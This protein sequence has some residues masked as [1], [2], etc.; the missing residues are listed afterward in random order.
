MAAGGASLTA[1]GSW[2][3][4]IHAGDPNAV[5]RVSQEP[6]REGAGVGARDRDVIFLPV[7]KGG[8][9]NSIC[10]PLE[11][12]RRFKASKTRSELADIVMSASSSYSTGVDTDGARDLGLGARIPGSDGAVT[13]ASA[14]TSR[15]TCAKPAGDKSSG[16][17]GVKRK[18]GRLRGLAR[19]GDVPGKGRDQASAHTKN[20]ME[21]GDQELQSER[22]EEEELRKDE[23]EGKEREGEAGDEK[24]L[25][26]G[27][28]DDVC[29]E[30]RLLWE[31]I[32]RAE[33]AAMCKL[34]EL[35]G[36]LCVMVSRSAQVEAW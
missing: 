14:D 29:R 17:G 6:G 13:G 24:H 31:D 35:R 3:T 1:A 10:H 9:A 2:S 19:V 5:S 21:G 8:E 18:S 4:A 11:H 7:W 26:E 32:K 33:A 28:N 20:C 16:R 34:V 30:T 36:V 12:P 27:E 23:G 15:N 25:A 22:K